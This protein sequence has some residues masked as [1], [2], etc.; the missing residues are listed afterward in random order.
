MK[1]LLVSAATILLAT[2]APAQPSERPNEAF[3]AVGDASLIFTLDEVVTTAFSFGNVTYGDA[4]DPYQL[5]GG[6]QRWWNRWASAGVTASFAQAR[7]TMYV[8]RRPTDTVHRRLTTVMVDGRAHWFRRERF[9]LYSGL[10]V[11]LA[12]WTDDWDVGPDEGTTGPAFHVIP[13]GVRAGRGL[14]AFLETGVGWHSVVKLGLS[15]RW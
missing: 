5:V 14:G 4:E 11:G 13:L 7:R 9:E 3:L 6:Y 12:R 10:A 15:R 1:T 8:M 2:A